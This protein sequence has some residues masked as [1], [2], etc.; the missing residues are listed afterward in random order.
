MS[1]LDFATMI[2]QIVEHAERTGM[3]EPLSAPIKIE[4]DNAA[5]ASAYPRR[6]GRQMRPDWHIQVRPI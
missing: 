6:S 3:I 1:A 2:A 5:I 4:V